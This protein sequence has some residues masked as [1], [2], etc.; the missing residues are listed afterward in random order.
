MGNVE[1]RLGLYCDA[2]GELIESSALAD[3]PVGWEQIAYG[4][5]DYQGRRLPILDIRALLR[6]RE[7][8]AIDASESGGGHDT[9]LDSY[10]AEA[11]SRAVNLPKR[12]KILVVN[13]SEFR[14]RDISRILQRFGHELNFS[15]ELLGALKRRERPEIDLVITDLRLGEEGMEDLSRVKEAYGGVPIVLTSSATREQAAELAGRFGADDCWLDPYRPEDLRKI[16]D[17]LFE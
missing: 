2:I 7:E 15:D 12:L 5:L 10:I 17:R 4:G 9:L 13:R 14:R 11:Q 6:L 16:L 3:V 8:D 1:R